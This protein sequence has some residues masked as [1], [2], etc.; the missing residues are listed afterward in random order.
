MNSSHIQHQEVG[1]KLLLIGGGRQ[2]SHWKYMYIKTPFSISRESGT[3]FSYTNLLANVAYCI[4]FWLLGNEHSNKLSL[5]VPYR[6]Q[7]AS[8]RIHNKSAHLESIHSWSPL[9]CLFHSGSAIWRHTSHSQLAA[10]NVYAIFLK[11]IWI[12]FQ[13]NMAFHLGM[14]GEF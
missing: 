4:N 2:L 7:R 13:W 9:Q 1:L 8:V 11:K 12:S 5:S 3:G 6:G 10:E 14:L